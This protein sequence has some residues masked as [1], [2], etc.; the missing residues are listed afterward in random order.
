MTNN[1]RNAW[2]NIS[3]S[4][5]ANI[6]KLLNASSP[7][8]NSNSGTSQ[9]TTPRVHFRD[10]N[11]SKPQAVNMTQFDK[12]ISLYHTFCDGS[13]DNNTDAQV[14]T[15]EPSIDAENLEEQDQL[16]AMLPKNKEIEQSQQRPGNIN[17]LL[18]KAHGKG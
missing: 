18:S 13:D 6:L 2:K 3:Q 4:G 14:N 7:S 15:T 16:Y 17:R 1:D 8:Q 10:K 12:F 5:K 9:R 11:L